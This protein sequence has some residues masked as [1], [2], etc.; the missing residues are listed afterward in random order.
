MIT[1]ESN[2]RFI[3]AIINWLSLFP[4]STI[5]SNDSFTKLCKPDVII[6]ILHLIL[7][8]N[9]QVDYETFEY[10]Q[11][12]MMINDLKTEVIREYEL[13]F[14][15]VRSY[16][17]ANMF[18]RKRIY[19]YL[20]LLKFEELSNGDV[21][22]ISVLCFIFLEIGIHSFK[23]SVAISQI[24]L[25][26]DEDQKELKN[27]MYDEEDI[28]G[29]NLILNQRLNLL[30]LENLNLKNELKL[31]LQE[32]NQLEKKFNIKSK[33][34]D[35]T[36]DEYSRCLKLK[37]DELIIISNEL[38]KFK[39]LNKDLKQEISQL[40]NDLEILTLQ[41]IENKESNLKL[42]NKKTLYLGKQQ[43]IDDQLE[44]PYELLKWEYNLLNEWIFRTNKLNKNKRVR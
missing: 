5:Y 27:F 21:F 31:K 41:K 8:E 20:D 13:I 12:L 7:D 30:E 6:E 29:K 28:T 43:G 3:T 14:K 11:N 26:N 39:I 32:F 42:K 34:D 4:D 24:S 40:T 16:Y 15:S 10:E 36:I 1:Q 25:L 38:K 19:K 37:E 2:I 23:S 22:S 35:Y 44:S 33:D 9:F 18:S 17:K